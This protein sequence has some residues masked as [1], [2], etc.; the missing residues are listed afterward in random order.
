[1]LQKGNKPVHFGSKRSIGTP[2]EQL[3]C[4]ECGEPILRWK[5][6][7]FNEANRVIHNLLEASTVGEIGKS[8]HKINASLEDRHAYHQSAIMEIEGTISNQTLS[9]LIDLGDT[10]SYITAKMMEIFELA[11]VRHMKP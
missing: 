4:W 8:F 10:L 6:P 3:R 11:K 9:I 2:K 5:C 7:R 1:M